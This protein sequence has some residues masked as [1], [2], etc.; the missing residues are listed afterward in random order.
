MAEFAGVMHVHSTFSDGVMSLPEIGQWALA[1]GLDFVCVTDHSSGLRGDRLA[2]FCS[3]CE[4]LSDDVLLVPGVE[5]EH[6][7]RHVLV[8]APPEGLVTLTDETAVRNPELVRERGGLSIWAHPSQSYAISLRDAIETCY[9]G[10]EIWNLKVDGQAPNVPVF[11]LLRRVA[12]ARPLLPFAGL[13]AHEQPTDNRPTL[14][15]TTEKSELTVEALLDSFRRGSYAIVSDALPPI[16]PGSPAIALGL[17]TRL[18]SY[19]RYG[20]TRARCAAAALRHRILTGAW[21]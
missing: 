2:A 10:W 4:S 14:R 21:P 15:V 11:S 5:F 7:G 19:A 12:K 1:E 8:I 17:A 18:R 20:A 3:E 9:D 6:S 13:D 16:T